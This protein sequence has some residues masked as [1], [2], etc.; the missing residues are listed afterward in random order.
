MRPP[1]SGGER[2]AEGVLLTSAAD[3][4]I[5][6][7][8]RRR[9]PRRSVYVG[10]Q[11][12]GQPERRRCRTATGSTVSPNG[13]GVG[14]DGHDRRNQS[15][16]ADVVAGL[17]RH[18]DLV[19]ATQARSAGP[20]AEVDAAVHDDRRGLLQRGE[21]AFDLPAQRIGV[22]HRTRGAR[23]PATAAAS[24]PSPR[25]WRCSPPP[26]R[27]KGD[28]GILCA[29]WTG[30]G[31]AAGPGLGRQDGGRRQWTADPGHHVGRA[32]RAILAGDR[33]LLR[34]RILPLE[35]GHELRVCAPAGWP[36]RRPLCRPAPALPGE[37]RP[38]LRPGQRQPMQGPV[39]GTSSVYPRPRLSCWRSRGRADAWS[40][41][42]RLSRTM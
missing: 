4:P 21:F 18:G 7:L 35:L 19:D 2:E 8:R 11:R 10:L 37:C 34:R 33:S 15:G 30:G 41:P 9:R 24:S 28:Q 36:Q 26:G 14:R 13:T 40:Y 5:R 39:R 23:R 12:A 17:D 42:L 27:R 1:T 32:R 29:T 31:A 38:P 25:C 22:A 6:D 20:A 3:A 16:I